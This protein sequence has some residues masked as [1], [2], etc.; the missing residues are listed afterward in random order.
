MQYDPTVRRRRDG[1]IDV[2]FYAARARAE[3]G[4]AA[5]QK[6]KQFGKRLES[7]FAGRDRSMRGM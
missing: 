5:R 2:E 1:S 3:R 7:V 4:L 6:I